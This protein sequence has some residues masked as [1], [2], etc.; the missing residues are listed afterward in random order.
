MPQYPNLLAIETA[1]PVCSVALKK[2]DGR[3][4]EKKI[5]GVGVHSEKTFLFIRDLLNA[6][7][8]AVQDLDAILFSNGPGS[9][10]GLRIGAAAIKGLLFGREI[11]LFTF[12]TL[13]SYAAGVNSEQPGITVHAV[14]DARR[15]H[16]Y[17]QTVT[18][19]F[20]EIGEPEVTELQKL[21]DVLRAEDII[22]GTGW[23]RLNLDSE[24]KI[25]CIGTEGI[26][27]SSLILAFGNTNLKSYFKNVS[28]QLF[29]PD[30]ITLSQVNNS[31]IRG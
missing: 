30:Y 1:T 5:E 4:I 25:R 26:S 19:G 11:P 21:K 8:I 28:P 2:A 15:N 17:R 29:E 31:T 6:E 13:L 22:I 18:S 16:L 20:K 12:P 23:D 14:I 24:Q 9:Y 7:G 27:A 3:I 10:T